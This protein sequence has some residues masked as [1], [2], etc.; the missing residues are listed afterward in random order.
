M[1]Y[2]GAKCSELGINR[3]TRLIIAKAGGL[4]SPNLTSFSEL[5]LSD[6]NSFCYYLRFIRIVNYANEGG[7]YQERY[8][9]HARR[10]PCDDAR[11]AEA[12]WI[13]NSLGNDLLTEY[14][15]LILEDE[16]VRTFSDLRI[17]EAEDFLFATRAYDAYRREVRSP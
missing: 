15:K 8:E 1:R 12:W 3:D 11:K 14:G 13:S 17:E 2:I 9:P 7:A 4:G 6:L 16:T 10:T 5:P